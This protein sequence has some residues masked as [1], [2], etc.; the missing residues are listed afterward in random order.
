[1]PRSSRFNPRNNPVPIVCE[2][3]WAPGSVCKDGGNLAPTGIWSPDSSARGESLYRLHHTD[4]LLSEYPAIIRDFN[5]TDFFISIRY[6]PTQLK[7]MEKCSRMT[8][9]SEFVRQQ[10]HFCCKVLSAV[11]DWRSWGKTQQIPLTK[12]CIPVEIRKGFTLNKVT[13]GFE[14]WFAGLIYTDNLTS[15]AECPTSC[16]QIIHLTQIC[17]QM[18]QGRLCFMY[19]DGHQR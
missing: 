14:C 2:A 8:I 12:I 5:L 10:S 9:K 13:Q 3:G 11:F 7:E 19:P 17:V 6:N 1:M 4:P 15:K 18:C 16:Y